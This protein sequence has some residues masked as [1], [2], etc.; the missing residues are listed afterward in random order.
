MKEQIVNQSTNQSI[1]QSIS[2]SVSQMHLKVKKNKRT[3]PSMLSVSL[4]GSIGNISLMRG[5]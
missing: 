3:I 1:S 5:K 2:Q 4:F